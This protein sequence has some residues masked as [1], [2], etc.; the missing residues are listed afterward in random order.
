M[1]TD[2]DR[3][4]NTYASRRQLVK[5]VF[6][7]GAISSQPTLLSRCILHVPSLTVICAISGVFGTAS[8]CG[9]PLTTPA[10][11][12]D[13]GR[14]DGAHVGHG[15][16]TPPGPVEPGVKR[17]ADVS[18][19]GPARVGLGSVRHGCPSIPVDG[20]LG[21]LVFVKKLFVHSAL[22][23]SPLTYTLPKNGLRVFTQKLITSVPH[24]IV[25]SPDWNIFSR[26]IFVFAYR[27]HRYWCPT[28]YKCVG[29]MVS[30]RHE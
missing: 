29:G 7:T 20:V 27:Q 12:P 15:G 18:K 3:E 23:Y 5:Y 25:G 10:I 22:P 26:V 17:V 8:I 1:K 6:Q 19:I 13:A 30:A 28:L 11:A 21:L 4:R 14:P 24:E 16:H 2:D 9:R